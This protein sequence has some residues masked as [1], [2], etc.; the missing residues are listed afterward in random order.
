MRFAISM[1]AIL[2][3]ASIIGTIV[4][5]DQPFNNYINQFGR[6][7]FVVYDT[8]SL[9]SVYHA[10]WFLLILAFLITSTSLCIY[11]NT[12]KM[13][14]DMR[15]YK[16]NMRERAFAS[17]PHHAELA[18]S[19]GGVERA[20]GYLHAMGFKSRKVENDSGTLLA[21]KKGSL[22]R[23][24]YIFAHVGMVVV[25]LGFLLDGDILLRSQLALGQKQIV[26]GNPLLSEVPATG[27]MG[28]SNPSFRGNMLVPEGGIRETAILAQGDGLLLQELPFRIRLKKFIIEHYSTGQPKLFAS[29]VV[30]T[31][32]DS[33][34]SFPARIEVNKPLIYRGVA[35][36]QSSFDDG[37]SHLTLTGFPLAGPRDYSFKIEGDVGT[38]T[39]LN[40]DGADKERALTLEFIGFRAFNVEAVADGKMGADT[41]P[42]SLADK[43]QQN[44][45]PGAS[46]GREKEVHNVGPSVQYKLRDAAGQAREYNNYMLPIAIEGKW[47]L[48]SGMRE[49]PD[50]QFRYIR[51]PMDAGGGLT[52]FMRLRAALN[53]PAVRALAGNRFAEQMGTRLN[54]PKLKFQ[55][56]ESAD[57]A[58]ERFSVQGFKSVADFI[59]KSVPAPERERAA[60]MFL[61]LLNGAT[62]EAWQVSREKAGLPRLTADASTGRFVQDSLNAISDS[63]FY[64][65]PVYFHLNAFDEVQASVFQLTRS[66]GKK[67]VYIGAL[68]L[69][70]GIFS[71]LYIRERRLWLLVK[72]DGRALLALSSQRR[73]LG[74]D[75]EFERHRNALAAVLAGGPGHALFPDPAPGPASAPGGQT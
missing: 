73:S 19:P 30:V 21:A 15:R 31:D 22:N 34:E 7:W 32:K 18:S 72:P 69:V 58:L 59:E 39:A 64:G 14:K 48:M 23:L 53:D 60:D 43:I 51:F 8:L 54:D 47:Y 75:D 55:L 50:D 29:D 16:E 4:S 37:G 28:L 3:I 38:S 33:G 35:V 17:F 68:L 62:W 65:S 6:F 25:C 1:L 63:F 71:M 24:G 74:L 45:G 11:R 27:R 2:A 12:P 5:Q 49:N 46:P 9:Y 61:S 57:R 42:K 13:L 44:L 40:A 66:P 26:H 52:E 41:A 10:W 67:I 70:T 20:Q 56:A 36:Y